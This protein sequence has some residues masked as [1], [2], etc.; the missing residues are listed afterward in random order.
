MTL[1]DADGTVVA[2]DRYQLPDADELLARYRSLVIARRFNEQAGALVR[3]GQLAVYPSTTGQEACQVA[4]AA[5]LRPG[6]WLFPTYRDSVAIM[7]RGV[8]PVE[9][10]TLL[11]GDWHCGYDPTVRHVA[12]QAT[13]LATQLPHAV[14][15]GYAATLRGED[16][17]VMRYGEHPPAA[18]PRSS[19]R[20]PTGSTRTPTPTTPAGTAARTRSSS[21]VPGI[22]CCACE[23]T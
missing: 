21:G 3:Q 6:D 13:P 14:G 15:V 16:T 12:P 2:D 9:V 17:V 11:R 8:D 22:R 1:I 10:L 20:T 23:S 18:A 19:R 7:E 4:A 5:V